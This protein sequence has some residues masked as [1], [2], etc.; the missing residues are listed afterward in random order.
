MTLFP[1]HEQLSRRFACLKVPSQPPSFTPR[2][3]YHHSLDLTMDATMVQVRILKFIL[4]F[5]NFALTPNAL[6]HLKDGAGQQSR[7]RGRG[8]KVIECR[9]LLLIY[10][11]N[12]VIINFYAFHCLYVQSL[13]IL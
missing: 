6:S 11:N 5:N 13:N 8:R 12:Y 4:Y 1:T 3:D 9:T 10:C 2:W 7:D